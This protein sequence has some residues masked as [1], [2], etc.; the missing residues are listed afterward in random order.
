MEKEIY[1]GHIPVLSK[2]ELKKKLELVKKNGCIISTNVYANKQIKS[3][4]IG[5]GDLRCEG[6]NGRK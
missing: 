3:I 5:L 6:Y 1:V 4:E 2:E